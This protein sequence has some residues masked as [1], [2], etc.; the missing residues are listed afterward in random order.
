MNFLAPLFLAGLGAIALPVWLHLL[1]TQTPER[2]PFSSAMLLKMSEQR[3]HLRR[4]LRYLTLLALRIALFVLAAL[5][6][7]QPLWQ[8]SATT[9]TAGDSREHL[10]V[11]DT[12]LSMGQGDRM[13]RAVTEARGI[14]DGL[15]AGDTARLVTA[16]ESVDI[17]ATSVPSTAA[18]PDTHTALTAALDTVRAGA[19]R[20]DFGVLAAGMSE[21]A[22]TGTEPVVLHL[23]SDF[24][25]SGLPSQF[26]ALI[27]RPL[28]NRTQELKLHP[29]ADAAAA[30]WAVDYLRRSAKGIDV[31]VRGYHTTP[32]EVTVT[33]SLNAAREERQTRSIPAGGALEYSFA[34]PDVAF[35]PGDNR[36][37]ASIAGVDQ[38]PADDKRYLVVPNVPAVP[39][40]LLTS[41]VQAPLVRYLSTAFATAA[42]QYRVEPANPASFDARTLERSPWVIADDLGAVSPALATTLTDYVMKGGSLFAAVSERSLALDTLPVTGHRVVKGE[43]AARAGQPFSVGRIDSS[44]PLL[45][46]TDGWR[47]ISVTRLLPVDVLEGD[48]V[49]IAMEDGRP[50]LI[51]RSL[52][53]GRILLLTTSLDN[54]WNDLP[55]HPVFVSFIA[56]IARYLSGEQTLN[57]QQIAG[58]NLPLSVTG[59][60]SGQVVDPEGRTILSLA[61]TLR[62]QEVRLRQLGFYQV[63]TPG[64]ET[65]VAVNADPRESDLE[66]ITA[67]QIS[68]WQQ[69]AVV[70]PQEAVSAEQTQVTPPPIE[71]W[72]YL[73]MLLALVVVAESL[74]GNRYLN[75]HL[76]GL[77]SDAGRASS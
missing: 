56:E 24:Q 15:G 38:L 50:L 36:I 11:I 74:L 52:G 14:I 66:P 48:R 41:R 62:A 10:I 53:E 17:V 61:D 73:L 54:T 33:V 37:M 4:R 23:I 28:A 30:N 64:K 16:G 1:Q 29:L 70:A 75:G 57:R 65:L 2:Q 34:L 22:G 3:I 42:R 9:A 45:A 67:E 60:A 51:E 44:H 21:L 77:E 39:V 27:P 18:A 58:S 46:A 7:A 5:A 35:A 32:A 20:L 72:R 59:G 13:A 49:L 12:S 43:A 25:A 68:R 76:H 55:V 40:A 63:Y 19:G 8:R 31:G 6:F 71:L 47:G 69:A 26:G